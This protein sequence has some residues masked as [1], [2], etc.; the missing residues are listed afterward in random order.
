MRKKFTKNCDVS[1]TSQLNKKGVAVS[2][3]DLITCS[4]WSSTQHNIHLEKLV[5]LF[6]W[7]KVRQCEHINVLISTLCMWT[8]PSI[9]VLMSTLYTWMCP[10]IN[11]LM[12]TLCTWMCPCVNI[13]MSILCMWACSCIN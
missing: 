8:C 2:K 13:L 4:H 12:S 6:F 3:M 9:N 5:K 7:K 1:L 11:V 10:C